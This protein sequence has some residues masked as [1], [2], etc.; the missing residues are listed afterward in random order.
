VGVHARDLGVHIGKLVKSRMSSASRSSTP[1]SARA[2]HRCTTTSPARWRCCVA[3]AP[4]TACASAGEVSISTA[5]N[6]NHGRFGPLDARLFLGS[7]ETVA[8]SVV[9]GCIMRLPPVS[10]AARG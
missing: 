6:H 1:S 8:A 2:A 7:P 5:T 4:P 3:G 10:P 9:A